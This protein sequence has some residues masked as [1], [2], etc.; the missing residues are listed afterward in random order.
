MV[1]SLRPVVKMFLSLRPVVKRVP[2]CKDCKYSFKHDNEYYCK[3]FRYIFLI[4]NET[5]T[6]EIFYIKAEECRINDD[7][8]G[9]SGSLFKKK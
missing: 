2:N 9:L 8:C 6:E 4:N 5:N 3:L 7:L 1:I